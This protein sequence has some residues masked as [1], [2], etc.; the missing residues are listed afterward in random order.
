METPAGV[1]IDFLLWGVGGGGVG[2]RSHEKW[3]SA[4]PLTSDVHLSTPLR[5]SEVACVVPLPI[6]PPPRLII[7]SLCVR[8]TLAEILNGSTH[9]P[10]HPPTHSSGKDF[11]E[12]AAYEATLDGEYPR[13]DDVAIR[14]SGR[15][16]GREGGGRSG[17]RNGE[18]TQ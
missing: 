6:H 13:N 12:S 10:T 8:D 1:S 2:K 15:E 9:P 17:W 14:P 11:P 5:R 18:A 16:G 3:A 4:A 7:I